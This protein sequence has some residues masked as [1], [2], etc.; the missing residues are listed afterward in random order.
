MKKNTCEETKN[1][2]NYVMPYLEKNMKVKWGYLSSF[3]SK[4]NHNSM[5]FLNALA[6]EVDGLY[7]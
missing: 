4:E 7:P 1:L 3:K 2:L 5:V 6:E